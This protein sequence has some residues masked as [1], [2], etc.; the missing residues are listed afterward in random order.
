[1]RVLAGMYTSYVT[2]YYSLDLHEFYMSF[3]KSGTKDLF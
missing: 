2:R 1:M 3:R